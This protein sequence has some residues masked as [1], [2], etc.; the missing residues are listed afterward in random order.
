MENI[1][2]CVVA[3][4]VMNWLKNWNGWWAFIC[5]FVDIMK[6]IKLKLETIYTMCKIK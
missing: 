6:T 2:L 4:E 1:E 5:F 3:E